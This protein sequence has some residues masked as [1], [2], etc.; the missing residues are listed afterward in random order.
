[1]G[2]IDWEWWAF[3]E[4]ADADN[5]AAIAKAHD[6][7]FQG[8]TSLSCP[9]CANARYNVWIFTGGGFGSPTQAAK[10]LAATKDLGKVLIDQCPEHPAF[11]KKT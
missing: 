8:I 1:V 11:I 3:R 6:G 9:S 10:M 5:E 4:G 2:A 7:G